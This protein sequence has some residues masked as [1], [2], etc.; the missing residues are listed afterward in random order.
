[1]VKEVIKEISHEHKGRYGNR[2][3]TKELYTLL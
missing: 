1:M 2:R 3:V